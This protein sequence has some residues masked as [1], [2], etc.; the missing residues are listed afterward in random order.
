MK[1][2][3]KFLYV[4]T[5]LALFISLYACKGL[6]GDV[7]P[8]GATGAT[9]ATGPAGASGSSGAIYS[10]WITPTFSSTTFSAT[11][12]APK[13]TQEILDRGA[14]HVYIKGTSLIFPL[15]YTDID[16]LGRVPF[17]LDFAAGVG[18][19]VI[20]TTAPISGI[21]FRYVLIPGST[22]SGRQAAVDFNNYEA[23]KK[24][25]DLPD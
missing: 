12:T 21:P 9:G 22:P 24:E 8:T 11:I 23:V 17:H 2:T 5:V 4:A 13:L 10:D 19:I 3:T 6:A 18:R 1:T 20:F 15:P 16:S 14:I 25:F 7:G